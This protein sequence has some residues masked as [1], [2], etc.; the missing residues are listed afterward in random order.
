MSLKQIAVRIPES[1]HTYIKIKAAA[2]S[3]SVQQVVTNIVSDYQSRD[4][5]YQAKL[6]QS[7][8]KSLVALAQMNDAEVS[9]GV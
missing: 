4:A 2:E 3:T 9:H 1:M 6:N 5:D 8:A 7:V